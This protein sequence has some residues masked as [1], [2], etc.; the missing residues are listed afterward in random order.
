[1]KKLSRSKIVKKLD[2]VF[3][4]YIRTRYADE[5][6]IV[7]CVTCNKRDHW[8]YMQAGHFMSRKNYSTRWDEDNV[9][10]QCKRCNMFNQGMQYEFSLHLGT[11]L[12]KK[13][14]TKSKQIVKYSNNDLIEMIKKYKSFCQ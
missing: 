6:G 3:S 14:H 12:S 9:Q 11:R 4:K 1:M 7:Q 2:D 8:K 5:F 13:L 10:V